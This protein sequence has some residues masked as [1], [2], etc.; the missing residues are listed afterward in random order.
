MSALQLDDISPEVEGDIEQEFQDDKPLH[1]RPDLDWERLESTFDATTSSAPSP[2][3]LFTILYYLFPITTLRFLREP[4]NC[5]AE[6]D[7]DTPYTVS[8]EEALD[9]DKIRC[10][11]EV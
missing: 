10:E 9:E 1:V 6:C 2:R 11:S 4:A 3:A 8:W 5:L 7:F